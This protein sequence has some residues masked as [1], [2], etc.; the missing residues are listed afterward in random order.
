MKTR[1]LVAFTAV[2]ALTVA[3]CGGGSGTLSEDDFVELM[4]D[5]C[6]DAERGLDRLDAPADLAGLESFSQDA[7]EVLTETSERLSKLKAP[8]DFAVDFDN[9]VANIDDQ[10]DALDDLEAAGRNDNDA[11]AEAAF[12]LL[13]DLNVER[14]QLGEDLGVDECVND[15]ETTTSDPVATEA[16]TTVPADT[17]PL[18]LPPTLP[19]QTAAPDTTP[20]ETV[21]IETIPSNGQLFT[22][23]DLSTVFVA[24]EDFTLVNSEPAAAQAFIDIV[25]SVPALNEGVLEMGVG[26]LLDATGTPVATI[27]AG[28]AIGD[29]MP[30]EWKDL[31][32]GTVGTLRTSASG[33][34]GITCPGAPDTG[35]SDIFTLTTEDLGL[36][37]AS[38]IEG[39]PA[40]VVAD[41]F[42]EANL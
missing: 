6:A 33:Y 20:V 35:V 31:L 14:S 29:A 24:P 42:F 2:A 16:A 17:V 34:I 5:I 23:V 1:S 36:T 8:D 26:V 4:A 27:V 40:D 10:I 37:V 11:A 22:V 7:S 28:I 41:A 19:P 21:P 39:L 13:G 30:G 9:F 25:A 32:C 15:D 18:T 38:L 3:S 12:V